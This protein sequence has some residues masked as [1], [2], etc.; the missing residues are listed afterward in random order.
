MSTLPAG[1]A[2]TLSPTP[3]GVTATT[4]RPLSLAGTISERRL[5]RALSRSQSASSRIGTTIA[6]SAGQVSPE[7]L[8]LSSLDDQL[9]SALLAKDIRLLRSDWLLQQQSPGQVL[10]RRQKL[11][12]LERQG[13]SPSPFLSADEAVALLRRCDRSVGVLSHGWLMP[14]ECDPRG[15]RMEAVILALRQNENLEAL[16]WEY[17]PL[18][19]SRRTFATLTISPRPYGKA[20]VVPWQLRALGPLH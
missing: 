15:V 16:F 2:A 11:E 10:Q 19:L 3:S 14:G 17:A 7:L 12:E 20:S 18:L 9:A 1:A 6:Q 5:Q 8:V 4:P 13:A